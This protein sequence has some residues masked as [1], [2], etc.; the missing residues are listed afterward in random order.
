MFLVLTTLQLPLVLPENMIYTASMTDEIADEL[1]QLWREPQGTKNPPAVKELRSLVH[2]K[3]LDQDAKIRSQLAS[4]KWN[5]EDQSA[6][7][8]LYG[9]S[10]GFEWVCHC[11]I[12]FQHQLICRQYTHQYCYLILERIYEVMQA[13]CTE[14]LDFRELFDAVFGI[15]VLRVMLS[16]RVAWLKR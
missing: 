7:H 11:A 15:T 6:I 9:T 3:I 5:I 16:G 8:L 13:G 2:K 1:E 14:I 10:Q 12:C 4:L